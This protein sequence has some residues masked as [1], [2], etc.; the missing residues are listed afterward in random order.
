MVF[1][2]LW[3]Y[4]KRLPP[5]GSWR[6]RRLRESAIQRNLRKLKITR[7][8]SVTLR[9]PP[10]SRRTAFVRAVSLLIVGSGFCP[11]LSGRERRDGARWA[12]PNGGGRPRAMLAPDASVGKTENGM[13]VLRI[14]LWYN[15][16]EKYLFHFEPFNLKK[17]LNMRNRF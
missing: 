2:N 16:A 8:P 11:I 15:S 1:F 14:I 6:R 10:S 9:V 12:P 17:L 4:T 3:D 7:A 5:G 13:I